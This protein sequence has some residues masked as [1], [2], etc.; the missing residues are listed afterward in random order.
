MINKTELKKYR[1]ILTAKETELAPQ[2]RKRDG[3]AIEKTPDVFD[4]VGLAAEREL[5]TRNLERESK[6]FRDVRAAMERIEEG[7]YGTCLNCEEEISAKRLDAVPWTSLCIDC[8]E[9]DDRR[10]RQGADHS[11]WL[12]RAA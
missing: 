5:M 9:L 7:S 3:I 4:E 8:Q 10:R 12:P 6:L 2:L 11:E 1:T